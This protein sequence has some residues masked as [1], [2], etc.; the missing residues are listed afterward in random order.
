M[1]I[2]ESF[3]IWA[4]IRF[5]SQFCVNMH[6]LLYTDNMSAMHAFTNMVSD[7][8]LVDY[9]IRIT[10]RLLQSTSSRLTLAFV[11]SEKNPA[12]IP[13]R[14]KVPFQFL[15]FQPNIFSAQ[16][17]GHIP[18]VHPVSRSSEEQALPQHQPSFEHTFATGPPDGEDALSFL[19][20]F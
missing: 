17:S 5:L 18:G 14:F 8:P 19:F 13:S 3:A 7:D 20:E 12:D 6:Y 4:S 1:F 11:P 9:F 10:M 2:L 16:S 15:H